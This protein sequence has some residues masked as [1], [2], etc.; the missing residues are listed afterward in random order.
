MDDNKEN[1]QENQ[2]E[3]KPIY[4]SVPVEEVAPEVETPISAEVEPTAAAPPDLTPPVYEENKKK[5]LMIIGGIVIFLIFFIIIFKLIFGGKGTA[6][7]VSLTYW[8]LWED[9][10]VFEPLIEQYRRT[11]PNIT[12]T[13]Q[14]M[15]PRNYREKLIARSK[16]GQ[17]P[18][19]FRFHNTWLPQLKEVAASLPSTIMSNNE[20]EKTFYRVAQK[21]LKI[22]NYY[23]GLPLEIDGLVLIYNENLFKKAAISSPPATWD[24][25]TDAVVKL[26]VKE[27]SGQLITAGIAIGTTSNVEH[28]SD[29]FGL[30]LVQNGGDIS[31][32]DQPEAAGALEIY[33]KF[34]EPPA[35]FWDDNMP[36][37]T[38]AFI[39]EKVAMIIA[40]SWEALVIKTANP[41]IS[42]KIAPVPT[43]PG[44]A[45]LSIANYWVEGVSRY[46]RQQ[47][48]A[49]KFLRF[50][51]EK[52]NMTKLYEIE[53]KLRPFGEPY[54]RVDLAPL[55]SQNEYLSSVI[56]QADYY[57]SLPLISRTYDNGLND[58]IIKYIENAINATAQGVS[59]AEALR[60][61]KRGIDQVWIKYKLK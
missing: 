10:Q 4:E 40:P 53:S 3:P 48:E 46:S 45:P 36:N 37:S 38:T 1:R 26:T 33:R 24:E 39:Q 23:Y 20:F 29:I 18:D 2:S 49:W 42:L 55:L 60:T 47:L 57:V 13:Y 61:A 43:V 34:A 8:G 51:T 59:Y 12:I 11:H 44:S 35:A 19:I 22:D 16:N 30:M 21:D 5:Y 58:E 28:F 14:K 15:D 17:G 27:R 56:K 54:S 52:D 31:K 6:K 32:L 9:I 50:L 7:P 25:L 41:D